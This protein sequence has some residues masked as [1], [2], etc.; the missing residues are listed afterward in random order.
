VRLLREP[1]QAGRGGFLIHEP[2]QG[3]SFKRFPIGIPLQLTQ[4]DEPL[5]F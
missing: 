5:P 4:Q 1:D 3:D 2:D